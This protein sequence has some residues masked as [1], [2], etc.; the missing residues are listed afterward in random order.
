MKP[1]R[2]A[3]SLALL[4]VWSCGCSVSAF[5][6]DQ[7][8]NHAQVEALQ[9]QVD[10]LRAQMAVLQEQI[11]TL[12]PTPQPAAAKAEE[13]DAEKSLMSK[14]PQVSKATS[15]YETFS[16][17]SVAA[18][19]MDNAPLDPRYPGY[20]RIPGTTTFMKIGGYFK[21]DFIYDLKPVGD[22]ER[23]IPSTIPVPTPAGVNNST[24]SVR[25]TRI[26]ADFLIPTE[27]VDTVR[28]FVEGDMFGSTSTTPRLRHA[29]AQVKNF[30]IGQ[31]FSNFQDP[32]SGP[33]QLEFQGPNG[34]VSIRN[35]QLRYAFKVGGK[36][37]LRFAVEKPTSDVAFKTPEFS[38]LPNS[39][40]PDGTIT[41]RHDMDSGHL[42]LS[43]LFR[44]V[45]AYLPDNRSDAVFGWGVNFTGSQRLIG[46][47]TFVYQGAYGFG[48]ERY[49][50][51]TSGLG[52]DAGVEGFERPHLVAIPV[53]G[54]YGG[55]QHFWNSRLRSSAI[56][57]FVQVENSDRQTDATFHKSHY[58]A[59]NLIWN[60]IGSLNVGTEFL[61]GWQ[62]KKDGSSGNASR[63]MFSAKYNFVQMKPPEKK[64]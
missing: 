49:L 35:P 61:Y 46:K 47:D 50:N 62:I 13:Q 16:Q 24:V 40:A 4:A 25:P 43:G 22:G 31:S 6:Q 57:G 30:L 3:V 5:P 27:S 7:N 34:Q 52:I 11:K 18:A 63:I 53:V 37:S 59:T 41:L 51:D 45:S 56:Y 39:P 29:Y 64:H 55:Y 2:I 21:S 44:S 54:T 23:F 1:R 36:T 15:E 8:T 42:Q 14:S 58:M 32:D 17:D 38:A 48:I 20:F 60:P 9:K 28:F 33:D 12:T 10:D 26:N 19:R